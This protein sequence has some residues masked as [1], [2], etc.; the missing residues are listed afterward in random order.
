R[1]GRCPE[2]S[3]SLGMGV[4]AETQS[5]RPSSG[6]SPTDRI[7]RCRPRITGEFEAIVTMKPGSRKPQPVEDMASAA[8]AS[9]PHRTLTVVAA[10]ADECDIASK[11]NQTRPP[12]S[13]LTGCLCDCL[14]RS[15]GRFLRRRLL[16]HFFDGRRLYCCLCWCRLYRRPLRSALLPGG[17]GILRGGLRS[18]CPLQCPAFL[19]GCDDCLPAS[20]T[21]FTFGF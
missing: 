19:R 13:L 14:C 16:H 5:I 17:C 11:L 12:P 8:T 4:H 21:E 9:C 3:T 18:F 10:V 1:A 20:R 15:R 2:Q 7:S 6:P